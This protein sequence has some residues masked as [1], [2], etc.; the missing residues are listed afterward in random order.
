M[1]TT[2]WSNLSPRQSEAGGATY[3]P[4][5]LTDQGE[6]NLMWNTQNIKFNL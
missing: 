6:I 3:P 5:V 1:E 2:N 4:E